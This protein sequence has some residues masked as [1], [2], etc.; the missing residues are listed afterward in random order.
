MIGDVVKLLVQHGGPAGLLTA[1][2]PK[3]VRGMMAQ[4]IAQAQ[5][6][7]EWKCAVMLWEAKRPDGTDTI[8]GQVWV[9]G[10]DDQPMRPLLTSDLVE[11][12]A[13]LDLSKLMA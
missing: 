4:L 12:F 13:Q 1:M 5:P 2:G 6:D 8:M 11:Q 10:D 9:L 7:P 3:W